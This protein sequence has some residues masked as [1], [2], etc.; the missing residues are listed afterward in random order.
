VRER[1]KCG[2]PSWEYVPRRELARVRRW[3]RCARAETALGWGQTGLLRR[4]SGSVSR[5][6]PQR[7]R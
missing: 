5:G 4:L 1:V 2:K 3:I 6:K 7:L